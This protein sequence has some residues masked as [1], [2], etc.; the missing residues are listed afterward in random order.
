YRLDEK[1][2]EPV[3][4]DR[5]TATAF[6]PEAEL[7]TLMARELLSPSLSLR[8]PAAPKRRLLPLPVAEVDPAVEVEALYALH[9]VGADLRERPKVTTTDGLV[10]V[11][12]T[13]AS[14]QRKT[15]LLAALTRIARESSVQIDI[16][17]DPTGMPPA[18]PKPEIGTIP[19]ADVLRR[20]FSDFLARRL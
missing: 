18:T 10:E 20:Y 13:V 1:A 7:M 6:E 5:V 4:A 11:Q 15:E 19:I 3:P 17:V 14:E 16:L 2:F 9:Q 8:L 12:A